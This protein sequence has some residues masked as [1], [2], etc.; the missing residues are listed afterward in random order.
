MDDNRDE[1]GP[2][3]AVPERYAIYQT[4][5]ICESFSLQISCFHFCQLIKQFLLRIF[6]SGGTQDPLHTGFRGVGS[7]CAYNRFDLTHVV[8]RLRLIR[9]AWKSLS[10]SNIMYHIVVFSECFFYFIISFSRRFSRL[11]LFFFFSY[12]KMEYS[13]PAL[14]KTTSSEAYTTYSERIRYFWIT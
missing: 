12:A 3:G 2:G 7:M 8:G 10:Q 4:S 13:V 5:L 1:R 14:Y 6:H 9:Q 11:F